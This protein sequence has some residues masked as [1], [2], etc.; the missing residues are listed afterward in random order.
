VELIK[1]TPMFMHGSGEE[2]TG[3]IYRRICGEEPSN[4][5][6]LCDPVYREAYERVK[7]GREQIRELVSNELEM[8]FRANSRAVK[9]RDPIK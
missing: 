6:V 8:N 7:S 1:Q 2:H 5:T 4:G 9:P 3:Y